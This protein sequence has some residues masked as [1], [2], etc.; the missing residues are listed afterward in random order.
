MG[1]YNDYYQRYY[2]SVGKKGSKQLMKRKTGPSNTTAYKYSGGNYKQGGSTGY[3]KNF[4]NKFIMQL[5]VVLVFMIVF[6]GCKTFENSYTR[7]FY[8]VS[9][10]I[11]NE[12]YNYALILDKIKGFN[13]GEIEGKSIMLIEKIK[14]SIT[15]GL[16]LQD[17]VKN[18]YALPVSMSNMKTNNES[19]LLAKGINKDNMMWVKLDKESTINSCQNGRVKKIGKDDSLGNYITIDHGKGIETKYNNLSEITVKVGDEVNKGDTIGMIKPQVP[20]FETFYFELL[21]M[22]ERQNVMDYFEV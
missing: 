11:I 16:T 17:E 4:T 18:D 12:N 3:F 22:G 2:A 9:K 15:G 14:S 13:L 8:D 21:Y 19:S 20:N 1:N 5:G 7:Q 10:K 6:L